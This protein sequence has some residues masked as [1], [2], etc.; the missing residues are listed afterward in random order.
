MSYSYRSLQRMTEDELI[1]EHDKHAKS[2]VVGISYYLDELARRESGKVNKTM[3]LC[4]KW[5][6]AMTA[7]M[8]LATLVNVAVAILK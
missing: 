4:T 3:L 6:T 1:N 7:V 5:I 2:T 8:L